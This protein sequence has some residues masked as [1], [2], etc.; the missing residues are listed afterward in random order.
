MIRSDVAGAVISFRR[1]GEAVPDAF[2]PCLIFLPL[3][4]L[5]FWVQFPVGLCL[6]FRGNTHAIGCAVEAG[7][8]ERWPD[9]HEG[10]KQ[11]HTTPFSYKTPSI[12]WPVH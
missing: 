5:A 10:G 4:L 6:S 9:Q 8:C 12:V 1:S 11:Q 3:S 2:D 7:G